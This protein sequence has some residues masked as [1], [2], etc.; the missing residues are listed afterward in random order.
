[1]KFLV[2][3]EGGAVRSVALA[4]VLR[5]DFGQQAVA[6]SGSKSDPE[7][8][9]LLSGWA[10]YIVVMWTPAVEKIRKKYAH[11]IRVFDIGP[12]I[13]LNSMHRDLLNK[14]GEQADK[15]KDAGWQL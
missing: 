13:W 8:V 11:K 3:C 9:D 10:D 6:I 4:S 7:L 15:W 2:V 12:D 1:M 5:W 14:V